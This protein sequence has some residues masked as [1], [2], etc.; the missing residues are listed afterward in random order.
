MGYLILIDHFNKHVWSGYQSRRRDTKHDGTAPSSVVKVPVVLAAVPRLRRRLLAP[1]AGPPSPWTK[2]LMSLWLAVGGWLCCLPPIMKTNCNL[3][4]WVWVP[5]VL[6]VQVLSSNYW[7]A[8]CK[9][10]D[11]FPFHQPKRKQKKNDMFPNPYIS[12]AA[13]QHWRWWAYIIEIRSSD[14]KCERRWCSG[15]LFDLDSK[16]CSI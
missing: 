13:A 10:A 12:L 6:F 3:M 15:S 11:M 5:T 16:T 7:V 9:P 1:G 8:T 14:G 2:N 4:S